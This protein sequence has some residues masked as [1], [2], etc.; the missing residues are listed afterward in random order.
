MKEQPLW[1]KEAPVSK[2]FER[3]ERLLT[4]F[5]E[6]EELRVDEEDASKKNLRHFVADFA[7]IFTTFDAT[8]EGSM[9][10][11]INNILPMPELAFGEKRKKLKEEV[12]SSFYRSR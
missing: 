3:A 2:N 4:D 8:P 7:R 12:N 6:N 5:Q 1:N 11:F 10:G 9:V